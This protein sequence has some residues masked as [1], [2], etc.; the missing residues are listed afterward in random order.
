MY[1]STVADMEMCDLIHFNN[2]TCH[3][4]IIIMVLDYPPPDVWYVNCDGKEGWVPA[5]LL[6]EFVDDAMQTSGESTPMSASS[7][8][9]SSDDSDMDGGEL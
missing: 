5:N 8:G 6:R 1:N 4:M 3:L 9:M 7:A 2:S